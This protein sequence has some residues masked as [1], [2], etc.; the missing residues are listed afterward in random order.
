MSA[1]TDA[2]PA[3]RHR[4]LAERFLAIADGVTDWQAPTPVKEWRALD[5]VEHL[6][7][8]PG[9]LAGMGVA[10]VATDD[11]AHPAEPADPA[12][13]VARLR[14]QTRAVQ[15]MLDA[16][17]ADRAIDTTMFGSLPLSQVIDQFYSFDLFAHAWD[18]AKACGQPADLDADYAAGAYA[19]MSAMGTALHASG[20]FGTPQPVAADAP[21]Q[22]KLIALIG[23]DPAWSP[24]GA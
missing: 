21:V 8:L 9:M 6:G 11:P 23:R 15:A 7:W 1:L 19:G 24:P 3:E 16:P 14:A 13:A 4:I 10:L 12:A 18:L 22:D 17:D 20:Q 2:T 5:I